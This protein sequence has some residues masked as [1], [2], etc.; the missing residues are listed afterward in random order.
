[1]KRNNSQRMNYKVMNTKGQK[2]KIILILIGILVATVAW[3]QT[4]EFSSSRDKKSFRWSNNNILQDFNV[5][6]RGDIELTDDD[7]DVKSISPGGYLEISKTTFGNRR[8]IIIRES[9]GQLVREYYEGRSKVPFDPNGKAWLADILPDL[10]RS[11]GIAARSRVNRFYKKAGVNGVM[12]EI[13]IISSDYVK[14]IY[15]KELYQLP[16]TNAEL[17][18]TIID[19]SRQVS[20]DY[21]LAQIMTSHAS[22]FMKSENT[23]AAYMQAS[24]NIGS[25]YYNAQVLTK[26][27]EDSKLSASVLKSLLE[28]ASGM[29]SDYYMATVL[30]KAIA[31]QEMNSSNLSLVV[32]ATENMSSDSYRSTVLKEALKHPSITSDSFA[33][34]MRSIGDMSSD[35]YISTVLK[36]LLDNHSGD[37]EQQFLN[38]IIQTTEDMSS[39]HYKSLILTQVVTE[40]DLSDSEFKAIGESVMRMSSDYYVSTVLVKAANK[41]NL[42]SNSMIAIIKASEQIASDHYKTEVLKKIAPKVKKDDQRAKDAFKQAVKSIRSDHYYGQLMRYLDF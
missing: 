22:K 9:G 18:S 42:S 34:L 40:F 33:S 19:L 36:D 4:T 39:D 12:D 26:A 3:S 10:V 6:Y 21:Y 13:E 1:M 30:Q 2:F 27:L 5:E 31:E 16:L 25:D 15:A 23:S 7:K 32:N 17:A 8:E 41:E 35:Y 20:S 28:S 14:Q 37:L 24:K 38:Q 11:T 29:G